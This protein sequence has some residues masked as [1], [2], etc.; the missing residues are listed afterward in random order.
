MSGSQGCRGSRVPVAGPYRPVEK[1][2]CCG[3]AR[4]GLPGPRA[5]QARSAIRVSAGEAAERPLACR[6][7]F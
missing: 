6:E 7:F 1:S 3:G 5:R 2:K 4:I